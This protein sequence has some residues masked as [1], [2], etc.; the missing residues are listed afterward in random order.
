MSIGCVVVCV[1]GVGW[2]VGCVVVCVGCVVGVW[3]CAFW[4]CGGV[5]VCVLG[6]WWCVLGG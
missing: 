3:W 2:C 1:V 5:Y 4:M 6:V